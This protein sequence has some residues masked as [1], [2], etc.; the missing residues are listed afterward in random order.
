MVA[1]N[2]RLRRAEKA[3]RIGD[4]FSEFERMTDEELEDRIR[5]LLQIGEAEWL[6]GGG[7]VEEFRAAWDADNVA[8]GMP[9]HDWS[10]LN[11]HDR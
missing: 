1:I 2:Q 11:E 9:P 10:L 8:N 4:E 3:L 7:T 5:A 6:K